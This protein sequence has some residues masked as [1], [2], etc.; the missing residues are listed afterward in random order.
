[1]SA[2][3][4]AL[5]VRAAVAFVVLATAACAA[6]EPESDGESAAQASTQNAPASIVA[7]TSCPKS[8]ASD[9]T[10]SRGPTAASAGRP[11]CP[12]VMRRSGRT[13]CVTSVDECELTGG[14]LEPSGAW[15]LNDNESERSC[16]FSIWTG[17]ASGD[18][19]EC[20]VGEGVGSWYAPKCTN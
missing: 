15:P 3:P 18:A 12:Y 20:T 10:F 7:M 13:Y 1:M 16:R 6:D 8:L 19:C 2:R 17:G 5:V 4:S 9:V 14:K 11:G